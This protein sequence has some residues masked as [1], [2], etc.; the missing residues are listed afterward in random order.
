MAFTA[1]GGTETTDG[2]YKVH[3]FTTTSQLVI[4]EGGDTE[5]LIVGGGG[6][7]EVGGG[8][9]GG[10]I[11]EAAITLTAGTYDVTVGTGGAGKANSTGTYA[12]SGLNSVIETNGLSVI[13]AAGGAAG[14]SVAG[15]PPGGDGAGGAASGQDGGV[16]L[17]YDTVLEGSDVYY[18]AGGG[19]GY[20]AGGTGGNGGGGRGDDYNANNAVAGTANTGGGGGGASSAT[21]RAG[22]DGGT[23]IVVI[24][25]LTADFGTCTGGTKTTDGDYTVHKFTST[26]QFVVS[27]SGNIIILLVGGGGSGRGCAGG[28][29]QGGYGGAV[30]YNAAY[31][32]TAGTKTVL[33]GAGGVGASAAIGTA[34]GRS[35]LYSGIFTSY[36]AYGGGGGAGNDS[37]GA[38]G[39][40]SGGG[41]GATGSGSAAGGAGVTGQGYKGGNVAHGGSPYPSGGGGGA[42]AE[43]QATQSNSISGSGG[44]GVTYD[45]VLG[46]TAGTATHGGG[47]GNESG[48]G[49][50]ATANTGGGGGGGNNGTSGGNGGKGIVVFRYIAYVNVV[51]NTPTNT[52]PANSATGVILNPTLV[53]STYSDTE[54]DAHTKSTWQIATDSGFSSVVWSKVDDATNKTS[55]VVNSTNGTFAGALAGK[56]KLGVSTVYYWRVKYS[57]ATAYS[58]YSTGTSFTTISPTVIKNAVDAQSPFDPDLMESVQKAGQF[59]TIDSIPSAEIAGL[60][61][62]LCLANDKLYWWTNGA[63]HTTA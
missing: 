33:V 31:A 35:A 24:R 14:T 53:G 58:A 27:G 16:G 41:G 51:P 23:G 34:G 25:Y 45:I 21:A 15:P 60:N 59:P 63:W 54:N 30:T 61:F 47:A 3:K 20:T 8:G 43:G 18:A 17:A 62:V 48:N 40:G 5:V 12:D 56:T 46:G 38:P 9:A 29:G 11:K 37:G 4:S 55:I 49:A 50:N 26:S 42:G 10:V 2:D 39:G 52:T 22:R 32:I 6:G 7:G 13:Q 19:S 1:T 36:T 44:A 57:D 28:G